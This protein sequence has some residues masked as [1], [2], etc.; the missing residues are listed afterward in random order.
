MGGGENKSTRHRADGLRA[1]EIRKRE[2]DARSVR[3]G[4]P[5]GERAGARSERRRRVL[6][7]QDRGHPQRL[8]NPIGLG[9]A[10]APEGGRRETGYSGSRGC[11]ATRSHGGDASDRGSIE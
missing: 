7:E 11:G 8:I 2:V 1:V 3:R 9:G 6:D 4:L 10:G 5:G